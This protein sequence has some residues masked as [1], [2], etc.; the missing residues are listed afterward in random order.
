M[1]IRQVEL[2]SQ[3]LLETKNFYKELLGFEVDRETQSQ[4]SFKVGTSLLIFKEAENIKPVYHFA[5]NIPKNKVLEAEKWISNKFPLISFESKQ[6]I[7][8]S[9]WNAKSIYFFD[10]NGNL[11]EF[12]ARFD[13]DNASDGVFNSR[14]VLS[15]SE[16]GFVTKN[17]NELAQK[18]VLENDLP[19][20]E[21]QVQQD[22]FSVI[23][24]ENGLLIIV[25]PER[26]WFPTNIKA[27]NFW[28]KVLIEKHGKLIALNSQ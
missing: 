24:G 16:I 8:F 20:F 10:N 22:N 27:E 28:M 4:I 14:S 9:H 17:V 2:L 23:G 3:N 1:E 18:F 12:I 26:N 19:L 21:K 11:L 6:I 5:F 13:L 25:D 7:D 15:I